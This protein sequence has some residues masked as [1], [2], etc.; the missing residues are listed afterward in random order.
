MSWRFYLCHDFI[1]V[2]EP[3][4]G[5]CSV[6]A[7]AAEPGVVGYEKRGDISRNPFVWTVLADDATHAALEADYRTVRGLTRQVV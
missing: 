1:D 2:D 4:I 7:I 3:G 5:P 6:P